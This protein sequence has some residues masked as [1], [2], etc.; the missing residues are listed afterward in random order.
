MDWTTKVSEIESLRSQKIFFSSKT[1]DKFWGPF[2]F[3][4]NI[5]QIKLSSRKAGGKTVMIHAH[6]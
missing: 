6:I 5:N 4:R 3:L 2:K 1:P